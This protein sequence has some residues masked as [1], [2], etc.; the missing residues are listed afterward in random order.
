MYPKD[1]LKKYWGY[2]SFRNQQEK[3]IESVLDKKDTIALLPTGGGKSICYQIPALLNEGLCLVVS[4]LI[5]LMKDQVESLNKKGI[6]AIGFQSNINSNE[7]I[8]LF[9]NIK[10]GNIKF[11]Y[12]SPERLQSDIILQKLK[13]IN[14]N[15]IAVDEAHCIS[16]WG[17]D[18][19]P[20]YRKIK[21]IRELFPKTPIIALTAT[22]TKKVID[23]I[24]TNLEMENVNIFKE[25]F[26]RNNVAYQI[27][28]KEN[29]LQ[30]LERVF[31]KNPSPTIVYV[32]SR[33]KTEE[34]A[35][36]INSRG[37]KA[38]FY[39]GG[40]PSED[41]NNSF[42]KWLKEER[43]IMVATNAFG[44]GID[45]SNVRIVAHLDLPNSIENYVQ[46]AG[47]GGRD[48]KKSFSIVLQ[49]ENDINSFKK[50]AD[51][52]T[53]TLSDIKKVHKSLYQYCNIVKGELVEESFDFNFQKFCDRYQLK[54]KKTSTI[55]KILKNNG[56]IDLNQ[57]FHEKSTVQFIISSKQFQ[58]YKST[59]Q[60]EKN[61]IEILLRNYGGIFQKETAINEFNLA[62]KLATTS[63]EIRKLLHRL[64]QK[65]I[66]VY[67]EKS[68]N[69]K[70][71]FLLP[72]EDDKTINRH[73]KSIQSYL[74]QQIKKTN[75]LIS[76]IKNN[77]VCRSQQILSYFD[78]PS[79]KECGI[80][81]VC[82]SNKK[83]KPV[84]LSEK[85][86]TLLNKHSAP[87]SQLEIIQLLKANEDAILIHLR[88]LLSKDVL[89][90]TNDNKL[91]LK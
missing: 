68:A 75:E 71:T 86:K 67:K 17:H 42:D 51:Q 83:T 62:K 81:D 87:L 10:Y 55:L 72:R 50:N 33:K 37:F 44:M 23:D 7:I 90:I 35:N 29:K 3:I 31:E 1:I 18:F 24:E 11:L 78:E 66:I 41:K 89:G 70:L 22:A 26:F 54:S 84:D 12:I 27:F 39:H 61:L 21:S 74:N 63:K 20:S 15:L 57:R 65:E 13:E 45:K 28:T 59:H 25:S 47:R 73:S 82:I 76:F 16:E 36:Y 38:V 34:I 30:L 80:C 69:E 19:R 46:E 48:G 6:K 49:N 77:R 4:P 79:S 40:M 56:I 52:K 5:S 60:P 53:P 2:H 14:L 9:D 43:P 91:F 58:T 64:H 88:S 32:N 8:A 85:I